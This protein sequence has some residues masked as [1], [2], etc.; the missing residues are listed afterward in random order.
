M[1]S[2]SFVNAAT[3]AVAGMF[4]LTPAPKNQPFFD[5]SVTPSVARVMFSVFE[6]TGDTVWSMPMSGEP[7]IVA[8]PADGTS[9][10]SSP[11][12]RTKL[13]DGKVKPVPHRNEPDGVEAGRL[14]AELV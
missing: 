9:P 4:Q 1:T 2:G 3:R 13:R 8:V 10:F 7:V 5:W 6:M 14:A 11:T 12:R